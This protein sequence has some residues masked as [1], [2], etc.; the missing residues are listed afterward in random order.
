M[1]RLSLVIP[2]YNESSNLP[3]LVKR[4]KMFEMHDD[5][6]VILVDNGSI[7]NTHEVMTKLLKSYDTIK[8]V[9]VEKNIGYGFGVLSG[10]K[11]AR[12]EYLAWTHADLQA[13][14]FDV[15]KGLEIAEENDKSH[16][17]FIKGRRYGRSL[18]DV[19]FTWA[20]SVFESLLLQKCLWDINGQP[21][22]FHRSFYESW[23]NPPYDFS[24]DLFVYYMA[25]NADLKVYRFPVLF[26]ER[27]SGIGHNDLLS[28]KIKFS[29]RTIKYS[30]NLRRHL[31]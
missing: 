31:K 25:K 11:V 9:T 16:S 10:L 12:G 21:N 22:I 19:V 28:S 13:D 29:L 23:E 5:I 1:I 15:M 18:R 2:C 26:G 4:C 3:E 20:M 30:L 24:L 17:V 8:M 14:P 27:L 6:E 7:D